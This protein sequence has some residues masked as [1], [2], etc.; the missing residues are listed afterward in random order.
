LES[1]INNT[2]AKLQRLSL[3]STEDAMYISLYTLGVTER[4]ERESRERGDMQCT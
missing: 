1:T 3:L 4:E 2:E